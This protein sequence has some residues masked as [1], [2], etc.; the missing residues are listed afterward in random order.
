MPVTYDP[1]DLWLGLFVHMVTQPAKNVTRALRR[2]GHSGYCRVLEECGL[3]IRS[4]AAYGLCVCAPGSCLL[5]FSFF[6]FRSF[7]MI[8]VK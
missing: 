7:V 4:T 8:F 6:I 2:F 1:R 5:E 3:F